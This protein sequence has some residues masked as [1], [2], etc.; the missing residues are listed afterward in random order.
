[1]SIPYVTIGGQEVALTP[2]GA[3]LHRTPPVLTPA[4]PKS[5]CQPGI[6]RGAMIA[7]LVALLG[8]SVI[9]VVWLRRQRSDH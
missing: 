2:D 5:P 9:L 4:T 8:L 1:M 3:A 6:G 7:G